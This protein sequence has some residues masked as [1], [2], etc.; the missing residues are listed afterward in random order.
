VNRVCPSAK[1]AVTPLIW[2][3]INR[4]VRPS[5]RVRLTLPRGPCRGGGG[6]PPSG[7]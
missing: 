4:E 2:V 1:L 5:P 3:P 6:T 7:V